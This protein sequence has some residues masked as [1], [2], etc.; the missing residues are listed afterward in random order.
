M[1]SKN[2]VFL[3]IKVQ[4]FISPLFFYRKKKSYI[5]SLDILKCIILSIIIWNSIDKSKI[6]KFKIFFP[7]YGWIK[8]G[9]WST[10]KNKLIN[11][12]LI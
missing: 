11:I 12:L 8:K 3:E 5:H 1:D 6:S 4:I 7:T 9:V 10:L 2:F